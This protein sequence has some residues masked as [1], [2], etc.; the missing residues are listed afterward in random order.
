MTLRIFGLIL[1][2][3][4]ALLGAV[5]VSSVV[6]AD[7]QAVL[8]GRL[9]EAFETPIDPADWAVRWRNTG[10]AIAVLA[11]GAFVGGTGFILGRR[12]AWTALT[13][14]LAGYSVLELAM[15]LRGPRVY[16]FESDWAQITVAFALTA[17]CGWATWRGRHTKAV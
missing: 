16:A 15:R 2:L 14:G 13:A 3:G 9:S 12:F 10:A 17:I 11:I 4:S 6:D 5:A 7:E 1:L 8:M